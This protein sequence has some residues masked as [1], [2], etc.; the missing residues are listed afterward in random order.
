MKP[1]KP[2][3]PF[4]LD[5]AP[6]AAIGAG[7]ARINIPEFQMRMDRNLDGEQDWGEGL[8][9]S[10]TPAFKSTSLGNMMINDCYR[11]ERFTQNRGPI[12]VNMN[13][14][15]YNKKVTR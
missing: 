7:G 1:I 13:S 12:T 9:A 2:F 14:H 5:M 15:F 4:E 3:K 8:G 11:K 10:K 6:G